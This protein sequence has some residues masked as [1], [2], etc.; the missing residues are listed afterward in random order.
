LGATRANGGNTT[1][2]VGATTVTAGGGALGPTILNDATGQ[3]VGGAGGTATNGDVNIPGNPGTGVT[4]V[5]AGATVTY[6]NGGASF[7]GG[8]GIASTSS[9]TGG[10]GSVGGGAGGANGNGTNG[11]G[12]NGM[13]IVWEY[14]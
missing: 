14:S 9:T 5:T 8:A 3:T 4:S 2:T 11:V 7:F 12:G 1:F 10:S 6:A 13:I